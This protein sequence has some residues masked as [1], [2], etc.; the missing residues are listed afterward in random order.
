MQR[1]QPVSNGARRTARAGGAG[2]RLL[3]VA[4][5]AA[6][7]AA[8]T[9]AP[10]A[11][12]TPAQATPGGAEPSADIVLSGVRL[13]RLVDGK[14]AASGAA[15][16]VAYLRSG[17]R[18]EARDVGLRLRAEGRG[19]VFVTA[20]EGSGFG[21]PRAGPLVLRGGVRAELLAA[22]KDGKES[23]KGEGRSIEPSRIGADVLTTDPKDRLV[24]LDGHFWLT[25]GDLLVRG[26]RAVGEPAQG[27]EAKAAPGLVSS[28]K[29][30]TVEGNVHVERAGRTADG[31]RAVYDLEASQVV[32]E[33]P[34]APGA[35]GP[36]LRDGQE[37]LSGARVLLF[38]E[39]D[40]V[41]VASPSLVLHRSQLAGKDEKG[42][43]QP[44]QI[45]ASQLRID[46]ERKVLHFT[47]DVRLQRGELLVRGPVLDA[48][49]GDEAAQGGER[50][51]GQEIVEAVV[52]GGASLRQGARRATGQTATYTASDRKVVLLGD[53]RLY[54][55]GDEARGER[56]ELEVDSGR[57]RI[58]K[59][60]SRIFP[61]RHQG[62]QGLSAQG[63]A[64]AEGRK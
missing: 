1:Q 43:P 21:D 57:V 49:Y 33:G 44:V 5:Q 14:V 42:P 29:K 13:D 22:R 39:R 56:I 37:R 52:S 8:C 36:V 30:V 19:Q 34:A 59:V 16:K 4:L 46:Q 6:L 63:Q 27:E 31:Q 38:T 64:G 60:R 26:D 61:A 3:L 10:A 23:K 15:A 32:L 47:G 17:G 45:D 62:E 11:V 53:P 9:A 25:R 18:F 35:A 55:Q 28:F 12:S 24:H 40:E 54:D 20:P 2:A 50:G 48:R 41:Q 7:Q 58:E 51:Q